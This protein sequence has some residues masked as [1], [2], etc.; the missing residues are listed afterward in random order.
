MS[1]TAPSGSTARR[2]PVLRWVLLALVLLP[3]IEIAVLVAVGRSIG[4][5]WTL[6]LVVAVA[7]L[8]TWLARRESSRTYRALQQALSSGRMP[9]D[10]VTDAILLTVG[11]LL[12][13]LP[14]FVSDVLAL[15]LVLPFTRPAAR[16]LLQALV[17]S[18]ALTV[19]GGPV[20][21]GG[22]RAGRPPGAGTVIDGEIVDEHP[23]P[24]DGESRPPLGP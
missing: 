8:G 10:E 15:L 20:G 4:L 9:A 23:P 24:R 5:W 17:A 13:L 12:L 3:L 18:R 1:T 7:V 19:V 14:G 22:R 16:R 21:P 11:G 6:F 2:R